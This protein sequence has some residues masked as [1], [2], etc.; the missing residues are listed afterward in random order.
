MSLINYGILSNYRKTWNR[1]VVNKLCWKQACHCGYVLKSLLYV[2]SH[3]F[4]IITF[5]ALNRELADT[6]CEAPKI[7][8]W[9]LLD[10]FL[11]HLFTAS[12]KN[13]RVI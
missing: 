3:R 12:N 5:S 2:L 7:L 1:P 11:C 10:I 4:F 8:K 13:I 9:V 6:F